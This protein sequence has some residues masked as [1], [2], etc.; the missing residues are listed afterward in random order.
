MPTVTPVTAPVLLT[1]ATP[2]LT[3]LQ[4]PPLVASVKF[5][6]SVGQTM[7]PPV[8]VPADGVVITVTIAVAAAD[9]QLLLTV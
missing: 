5:I 2:V 8:I 4:V 9:P 6:T 3:L 7:S 1:V